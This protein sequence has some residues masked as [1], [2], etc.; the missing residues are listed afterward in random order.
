MASCPLEPEP[1]VLITT[2]HEPGDGHTTRAH[3]LAGELHG[4]RLRI[5]VVP[6]E[7]QS[8]VKLLEA[9]DA[10]AVLVLS[11]SGTLLR[12]RDGAEL[13]LTGTMVVPKST[14]TRST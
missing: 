10:C 7:R 8:L 2:G 11:S 9:D 5:K 4:A 13:K 3:A 6:R 12:L 1:V 14:N